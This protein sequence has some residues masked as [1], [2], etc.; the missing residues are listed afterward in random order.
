MEDEL[1]AEGSSRSGEIGQQ[2]AESQ[3]YGAESLGGEEA[4]AESGTLTST[5]A[6][7]EPDIIPVLETPSISM[8]AG[9]D[10]WADPSPVA[11]MASAISGSKRPARDNPWASNTPD[12][13]AEGT[14][15][16]SAEA[17]ASR[18]EET[19]TQAHL[20]DRWGELHLPKLGNTLARYWSFKPG[21][22]QLNSGKA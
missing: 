13:G 7:E 11:A 3:E 22:L 17:V 5:S 19:Q 18:L 2:D 14:T 4:L 21:L 6:A 10:P 9:A 12:L 15:F 16:P 8:S 1:H 20:D